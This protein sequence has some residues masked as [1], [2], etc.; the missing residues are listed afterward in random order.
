M[1]EWLY[2]TLAGAWWLIGAPL[3]AFLMLYLAY[4]LAERPKR[5]TSKDK[6][7]K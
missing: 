3:S 5:K 7:G 4:R 6:K 1:P 2:W